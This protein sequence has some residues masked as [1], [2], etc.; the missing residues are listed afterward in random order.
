MGW[1]LGQEFLLWLD[2]F[3][4]ASLLTPLMAGDDADTGEKVGLS[5]CFWRKKVVGF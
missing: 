1:E 5:R 4:Q 2:C 3:S